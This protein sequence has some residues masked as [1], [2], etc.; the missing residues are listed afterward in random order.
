VNELLYDNTAESAYATLFFAE[1]DDPARRLRYG[2][3]GHLPALLLRRDGAVERLHSTCTVL[4]LFK[5]WDCSIAER[6]L[7]PGDTLV[8]YTDGV[9]ETFNASGEEFGEQ[10]LIESV[11]RHTELSPEALVASIV[12]EVQRF[13]PHE[14]HDDITLIVAKCRGDGQASLWDS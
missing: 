11:K 4:G 3:C 7:F 5:E 6:Q 13:S 8:L 2:N 12:D 1:Y 14:Q 9:T 10:R